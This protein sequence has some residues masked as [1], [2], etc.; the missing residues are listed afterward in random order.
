ME[1]LK[2]KF[3]DKALSL[4]QELRAISKAEGGLKVDEVTLGQVLGGAR[5]IKMMLWETSQ[6]D[7]NKGITLSRLLHTRD[8]GASCPADPRGS[9]SRKAFF[10]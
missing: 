5:S 10:G 3:A 4:Y 6:L 1:A 7:A 2:Q 9:L 8:S